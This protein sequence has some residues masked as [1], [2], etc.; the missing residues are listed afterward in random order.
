M[1]KKLVVPSH[2]KKPLEFW[3]KYLE[4]NAF[5]GIDFMMT[6]ARYGVITS[7]RGKG[8]YGYLDIVND[9]ITDCVIC[10]SITKDEVNFLSQ[11]IRIPVEELSKFETV[12]F[13]AENNSW[14]LKP[15]DV[16]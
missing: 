12:T 5:S 2:I 10:I 16:K 14:K 3:S 7:F 11:A 4:N 15:Y 9:T 8:V 13:S 6:D 1:K